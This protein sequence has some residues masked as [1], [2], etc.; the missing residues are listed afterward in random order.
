MTPIELEG[1]NW[2]GFDQAYILFINQNGECFPIKFA[3]GTTITPDENKFC[4]FLPSE[5]TEEENA[6]AI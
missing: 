4:T 3:D 6:S 2:K 1:D 5:V